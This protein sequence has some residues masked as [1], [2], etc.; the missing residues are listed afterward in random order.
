[1]VGYS[2]DFYAMHAQHAADV[3][4]SLVA[5][6]LA[7]RSVLDVGCGV[8]VWLAR[9]QQDGADVLG[10]DG[11]YLDRATLLVG[12]DQFRA[13]DLEQ[14]FD[15]GRTYD[16]VESLEVAEHIAAEHADTFVDSLAR[17]GD[18][19]LFSA[20]IPNQPGEFHVNCRWPSFWAEKFAARGFEAFDII[21]PR[22]WTDESIVWWYRQ[23]TV[24]YARGDALAQARRR[25][26]RPFPLDLVHP[27]WYLDKSV[28]YPLHQVA[29]N[30]AVDVGMT[31]RRRFGR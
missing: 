18:A 6:W 30:L 31:L 2:H 25:P 20:A 16:L 28:K 13:V 9:W 21:R 29:R 11:D 26:E 5:D 27:R 10:L 14:T 7:P 3:I 12:E 22:I 19:I 24:I 23:N 1:M 17:H 15:M 8:G 4:V